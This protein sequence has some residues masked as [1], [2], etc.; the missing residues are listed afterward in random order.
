MKTDKYNKHSKP[1]NEVNLLGGH[2]RLLSADN[3]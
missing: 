2:E 3:I 1:K